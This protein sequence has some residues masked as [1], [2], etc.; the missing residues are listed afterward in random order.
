MKRQRLYLV[1]NAGKVKPYRIKNSDAKHFRHEETEDGGI[2]LVA[3]SGEGT[4]LEGARSVILLTE[5]DAKKMNHLGL[6]PVQLP[7][8]LILPDELPLPVPVF[9]RL[10][11]VPP[12]PP[13]PRAAPR[14]ISF[15]VSVDVPPQGTRENEMLAFVLFCL[16]SGL[17]F[18]GLHLWAKFG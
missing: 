6:E 13:P 17:I 4:L 9:E 16:A 8:P 18:G 12:L 3:Y 5:E 15:N 2:E 7:I 1:R 14:P 10:P 11:D